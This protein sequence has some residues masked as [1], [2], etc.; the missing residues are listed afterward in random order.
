V[1]D[2][3]VFA[4][5]DRDPDRLAL[6]DPQER[7]VTYGELTAHMH[8]FAR[9]L[10]ARGLG[11]GDTL[12]VVLPNCREFVELYGAAVESGLTFVALN[13][14][15]GAEELAYVLDDAG[16]RAVVTTA[17]FAEATITAA[18]QAGIEARTRFSIDDAPGMR[19][20]AELGDGQPD[21]PLESPRVGRIMFYTSGTTGK[22]KGVHKHVAG[23]DDRDIALIAGIGLRPTAFAAL[24]SV[25]ADRRVDFACGPMYHAAP[26]ASVCGAL[27]N[28]ALLVMLDRWTPEDF[29]HRVERYHVTNV[30]MVPTM[31]HRLLALPEEQRRAADVSSLEV[32]SHAGAPCPIDV[33]R[34]M[35]EWWGPIILE[36]YSSTEG[37]GTSV[38][39]EEWLRKP[40]TVGKP[41]AGVTVT[42]VDDEGNE[43]PPGVPGLVFV[44][45]TLWQFEYH[46]DLAKTEAGRR[47][48]LFT[49]GD[50]GYLDED[51]YL[52]LCDRQADVIVSG[53]VNVYPAEV[54]A[55][56]LTHAA[57]ADAAVVGVPSDEWGEE[58]RA[59]VEV[60]VGVDAGAALGDELVAYCRDRLAHY[61][62]PR[63]VDFVGSLGRDPN[64][65]LR[66]QTIRDRYWE[67][68]DRKI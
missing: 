30:S 27:D 32:V 10:Q 52:F 23:V 34:R 64:G 3:G 51:G 60:T 58:V 47:G 7:T 31:F 41:S 1:G 19:P 15:L 33:K 49:V 59:V 28:G 44:S 40:G 25:P 16:A 57:V 20:L 35:I 22:P 67:G 12:A 46:N 29:L 26:L 50:I 14:H 24:A 37:A 21:S 5:A 13:W 63:A 39:S 9:G 4:V 18:D 43:C 8:E 17:R 38:T 11:P 42:I 6:V 55:T 62:C 53:G 45:Q 65:K 68:R 56:L 36:A 54:E 48:D 61:K 66:K 2:F